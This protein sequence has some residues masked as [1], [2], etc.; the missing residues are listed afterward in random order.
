MQKRGREP[1]A[2]GLNLNVWKM[3]P[4]IAKAEHQR[5]IF[6]TTE[7]RCPSARSEQTA[8]AISN[9]I[10]SGSYT[11]VS[12][13]G[14]DDPALRL[15]AKPVAALLPEVKVG[16]AVSCS[17]SKNG[18]EAAA[19]NFGIVRW[20]GRVYEALAAALLLTDAPRP[21][22][23][24]LAGA[25]SSSPAR[26]FFALTFVPGRGTCTSR[27]SLIPRLI[28]AFNKESTV[29]NNPVTRNKHTVLGQS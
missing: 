27:N 15:F 11:L 4:L 8:T 3:L 16:R 18:G 22:Y 13:A 28:R 24:T 21:A 1:S 25:D 29:C 5:R 12:V 7:L 14:F 10:S 6:Q 20:N 23:T 17:M 26:L 19:F 2:L 9:R